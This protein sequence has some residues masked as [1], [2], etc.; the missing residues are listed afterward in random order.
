M[1]DSSA[2]I[3]YPEILKLKNF[4]DNILKMEL[5]EDVDKSYQQFVSFIDETEELTRIK[6]DCLTAGIKQSQQELLHLTHIEDVTEKMSQL[7]NILK[8]RQSMLSQMK[9]SL[10]NVNLLQ[11]FVFESPH[12]LN[13]NSGNFDQ[14]IQLSNN[15]VK[16]KAETKG[17]QP[18]RDLL[19]FRCR[20]FGHC[21]NQQENQKSP[22]EQESHNFRTHPRRCQQRCQNSEFV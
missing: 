6:N 7:S 15:R 20:F 8:R 19:I 12:F 1:D 21:P 9:S 2:P 10:A 22:G 16:I 4:C 18:G 17:D 3:L 13:M 11:Y 14:Y 5:N